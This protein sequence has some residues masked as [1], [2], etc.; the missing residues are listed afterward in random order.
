MPDG[1]PMISLL[2]RRTG[3]GPSPGEVERW[4]SYAEALE[5]VLTTAAD[6][7]AEM[8]DADDDDIEPPLL[9]WLQRML[10]G[11]APLHEKLVLFWHSHFASSADKASADMMVRQ[12]N[13]LRRHALGDF[14]TLLAAVLGDAA[15]LVFLDSAGSQADSPNENLARELLELFTL[16]RGNYTEDDVKA[17][18]RALAG[19]TVDWDS[20]A[21]GFDEEAAYRGR[22]TILGVT[23]HFD[24]DRLVEVICAH[25]ACARFVAAKLYRFL[26]GGA[27]TDPVLDALAAGFASSGLQLLPLVEAILRSPELTAAGSGRA[28]FP[29]EWFTL[30]HLALGLPLVTDDVWSVGELGQLPMHPPNVAGWQ[31]GRHWLNSGR[32]LLRASMAI[33]VDTAA[34]DVDLGGGPPDQRVGAALARC[35]IFDASPTTADSLAAM[36]RRVSADDGGDVLLV[37]AALAS[38]EA[39]CC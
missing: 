25:P 21:V 38:P 12:H 4:S 17:A 1:L 2:L 18:A 33:G 3:F 39:A 31:V 15:M 34:L 7:G 32:Q 19:F 27:P 6:D 35:A 23:D 30:R 16:G 8:P 20:E 10:G 36:A 11:P 5:H 9:W 13:V 26:V 14:P 22:S 24:V 29:V 37:M 28:R